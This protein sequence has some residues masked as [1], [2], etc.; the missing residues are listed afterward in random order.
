[1]AATPYITVIIG[2]CWILASVGKDITNA[3]HELNMTIRDESSARN[4]REIQSQYCNISKRISDA[5]QLSKI[6]MRYAL[7]ELN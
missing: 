2:T 7:L 5:K 6:E 4:W 1:M 3:L